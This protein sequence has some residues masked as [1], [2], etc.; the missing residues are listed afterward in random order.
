MNNRAAAIVNISV[1]PVNEYAPVIIDGLT[2]LT[3][4][5]GEDTPVGTIILSTEPGQGQQQYEVEDADDGPD[6]QITFTLSSRTD[7]DFLQ[8]FGLNPNSGVLNVAQ[9]LFRASSSLVL[10][11]NI[12]VCDTTPSRA[13]C[14]DLAVTVV[15]TPS[16]AM[17]DPMF[18]RSGVQAIL[19][20]SA[21]LGTLVAS[22]VCS[23]GDLGLGAYAGINIQSVTPETYADTFGLNSTEDGYGVLWLCH[24]LDYDTL[25]AQQTIN[26]SLRCFDNQLTPSEDF[27]EVIVNVLPVND[28]A[29]QFSQTQYDFTINIASDV[30]TICCLLATD[31]DRHV[32]NQITYSLDD[33]QRRFTVQSNGEISF[34]VSALSDR[35]GLTFILTA[36][37]SDGEFDTTARVSISVTED[38]ASVIRFGVTEI[39]IVAAV[40]GGAVLLSA[41][42]GIICCCYLC[43]SNK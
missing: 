18:N 2:R 7:S 40:C 14:P 15:L 28:N 33:V 25:Q 24:S 9:S 16:V 32:G 20:E 12:I 13:E 34:D 23:D 8:L 27:A 10:N 5:I 22:I 37:A 35:V 43:L 6:G 4:H 3:L 42:I 21:E 11:G 29:P 36:I 39:G 38:R 1:L 30:E 26:I 19:P 17:Y 31:A 41:T